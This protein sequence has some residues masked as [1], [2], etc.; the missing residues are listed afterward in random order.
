MNWGGC[1]SWGWGLRER[2]REPFGGDSGPRSVGGLGD[3][4]EC[5]WQD[6]GVVRREELLAAECDLFP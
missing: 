1:G 3:V 4:E 6:L 5:G 2:E